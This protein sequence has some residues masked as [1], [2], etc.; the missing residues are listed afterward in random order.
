M[1][2]AAGVDPYRFSLREIFCLLEG[3]RSEMWDYVSW[4]CYFMPSFGKKSRKIEKYNAF[5]IRKKEKEKILAKIEYET[6]RAQVDLPDELSENERKGI[7]ERLR[8]K[9][10]K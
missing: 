10:A 9:W 3:K 4:I 5:L 6:V 8:N 7:F 1:A 2:G